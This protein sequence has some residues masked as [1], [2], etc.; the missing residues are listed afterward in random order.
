MTN[1]PLKGRYHFNKL[2]TCNSDVL[3]GGGP[4][5]ATPSFL[6]S[7]AWKAEDTTY[8]FIDIHHTLGSPRKAKPIR[9]EEVQQI[10]S[11]PPF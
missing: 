1:L 10:A 9:N 5:A 3:M 2:L 7:D 6:L 11:T 8:G 4:G